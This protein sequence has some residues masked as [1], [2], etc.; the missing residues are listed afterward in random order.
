MKKISILFLVLIAFAC[1][2]H[3]INVPDYEVQKLVN[4]YSQHASDYT[5]TTYYNDWSGTVHTIVVET[6]RAPAQANWSATAV[7]SDYVLVGGGAYTN[8]PSPGAYLIGSYPDW[9][10][11]TWWAFSKDHHVVN[12]HEIRVY[13]VGLKI[14]GVTKSV[15]K[16]AMQFVQ[17]GWSGATNHPSK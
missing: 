17:S 2:D 3:Q 14:D 6:T 12:S 9:S 16:S 15:L 10:T 4:G 1:S 8:N 7:P 13:A 5:S 11:D